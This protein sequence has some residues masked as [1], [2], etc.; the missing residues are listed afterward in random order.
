MAK[1]KVKTKKAATKK[2]ALKSRVKTLNKGII[3]T[4][5]TVYNISKE[6]GK[7]WNAFLTK[8]VKQTEPLTEKQIDLAFDVA[9]RAKLQ[10]VI[11]KERFESLFGLEQPLGK[12]ITETLSPKNVA[13]NVANKVSDTVSKIGAYVSKA[14]KEGEELTAK[15]KKKAKKMAKKSATKIKVTKEVAEDLVEMAE[16]KAQEVVGATKAKVS[17]KKTSPKKA[18]TAK[19][20][21]AAKKEAGDDLSMIKG[22]GP[23]TVE[24][25]N[26]LGIYSFEAIQKLTNAELDAVIGSLGNRFK[27]TKAA[28]WKKQTKVAWANKK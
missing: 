16:D 2:A 8:A 7:K 4:S 12:T 17:S 15:A 28:D 14:E 21:K 27:T 3:T 23:K 6:L 1:A 11:G 19:K 10:V 26:E 22:V 5:D 18:K 25:L 13:N 24:K 9:E 20:A